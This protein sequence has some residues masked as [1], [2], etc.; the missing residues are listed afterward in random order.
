MVY[1]CKSMK[2]LDVSQIRTQKVLNMAYL[3]Y[4]CSSLNKLP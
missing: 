2:T 3:F 4:N 1:N